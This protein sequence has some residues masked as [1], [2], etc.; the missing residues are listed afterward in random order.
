MM[1]HVHDKIADLLRD[2]GVEGE[3]QLTVPPNPEL[4]DVAFACFNLSKQ[5]QKS[6]A[7]VA[8]DLMNKLEAH[9]FER[10]PLVQDA[11]TAGPY[12][13]FFIKTSE[14]A[15][16]VL[17]GIAEQGEAYG[18][19]AV[20]AGKKVLIEYPSEN[21]HKEFHIGHLRNVCIGNTLVQLYRASGYDL[22]AIN[23]IND[24][25]AHV[26]KCLW[27]LRKFH[28]GVEPPAN[29][30]RW[31]GVVY[32]EASKYIKEHEV[33]VK[34]ELDELQKKLEA[35]DPEIWP[36]FET[37][38]A[39]SLEGFKKI[40]TELGISYTRIFLESEVKDRGQQLVDELLQKGVATV[41]EKGAIIIDLTPYDLDIAMVR[42]STGAGVYL[43]SDLA[44]AEKKF[45]E[46]P[47]DES[48][49]ITGIEQNFYFK[50]LFKALELSG[51]QKKMTHIGYGLVNR[52]DGK[53]S[54]R[55]GNV[56]L[57]DELRDEIAHRLWEASAARH[58]DWPQEKLTALV[59]TLT[60]S[61]L[62]F[63]MQQHEAAK[64]ITF[65]LEQATNF[66]GYSAP[67]VLYVVARINSLFKKAGHGRGLMVVDYDLLIEKE[68]KQLLLVLADFPTVLQKALNHHNPA[69]IS[70]YSFD[71]AK[72]FNDW[73]ANQLI[74]DVE[75]ELQ[76]ARLALA[77][78]AQTV[79]TAALGLL[80]ITTVDEM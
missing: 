66:E 7:A 60:L 34:P 39:W 19:T 78:A 58:A 29:P 50:Q 16:L 3:I 44:L 18:H 36:L 74:V 24:F 56:I 64:N 68:E 69:V 76:S 77:S 40:D 32:A 11:A 71:L 35:R 9:H 30:Q 45:Q 41:G 55:L 65:D 17:T 12:L 31:L 6:P 46:F 38:R 25:G 59:K 80:T 26:V 47:V 67:Y 33:E 51:F 22:T 27:G 75:A 10:Y 73:Y 23:Y 15:K 42:K 4:G 49:N 63:S 62:K 13:N 28:A 14:L 61:V 21:T 5:L 54:S 37:T 2:I 53:M 43:T 57:Y 52:P 8:Q 72:T 48:I 1:Q 79:L 70:K 20:G